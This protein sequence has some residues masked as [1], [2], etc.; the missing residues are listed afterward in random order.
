MTDN[1]DN[2]KVSDEQRD[3]DSKVDAIAAV[4][5]IFTLAAMAVFWV[6]SQ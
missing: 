3:A 6:S 4:G 5:I 2:I 1:K